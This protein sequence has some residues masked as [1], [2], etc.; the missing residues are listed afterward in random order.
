[1][2]VSRLLVYT[3]F[4]GTFLLAVRLPEGRAADGGDRPPDPEVRL[5]QVES[6]VV[7]KMREISAARL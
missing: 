1:M 4:F 5:S 3:A 7:E 6:Q 2:S